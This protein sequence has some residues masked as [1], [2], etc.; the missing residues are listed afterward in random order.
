MKLTDFLSDNRSTLVKKWIDVVIDSYP[1]DAQR[2][3]HKEKNRFANPIGQTIAE[4]VERL[5]DGLAAGEDRQETVSHL[6]NILR[7]QAVQ[8][9]EASRAVSFVFKLK[10]LVRDTLKGRH[11]VNGVSDELTE[12][13]SKMDDLALL[14]FDVYTARRKRIYELRVDEMKRNIAGLLRRANLL[15]EIPG[16]D[17]EQ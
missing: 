12:F 1:A 11:S 15:C 14:A 6:D 16:L 8:D 2:F 9:F 10:V 17:P 13:E 4:E 5:Y 3:F 7:I